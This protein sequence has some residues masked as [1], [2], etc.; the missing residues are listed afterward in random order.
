MSVSFDV[1]LQFADQYIDCGFYWNAF[2]ILASG[3][4]DLTAEIDSLDPKVRRVD[5]ILT[6]NPESIESRPGVD[7]IWGKEIVFKDVPLTRHD[8][9]ET[10][11]QPPIGSS[12]MN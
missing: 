5:V 1:T 7:I 4:T 2:E 9:A 6:P 12:I 11:T 3:S 8:L 10:S